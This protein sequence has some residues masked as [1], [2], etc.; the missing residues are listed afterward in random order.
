MEAWDLYDRDPF[1]DRIGSCFNDFNQEHST[2]VMKPFSKKCV[3]NDYLFYIGCIILCNILLT[4]IFK[5]LQQFRVFRSQET[6]LCV[7]NLK[8][9]KVLI[10]IPRGW[11]PS[12]IWKWLEHRQQICL[13]L[14][15]LQHGPE[16]PT[17]GSQCCS[18]HVPS[19]STAIWDLP[20]GMLTSITQNGNFGGV[21]LNQNQKTHFT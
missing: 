19:Q 8:S 21:E 18:F 15:S 12:F 9:E 14:Q 17:G 4:W 2:V 16:E 13:L 7:W 3:G 1:E 5:V 10:G 11:W 20:T 6:P